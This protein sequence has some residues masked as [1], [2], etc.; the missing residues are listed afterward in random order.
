MKIFIET[1]RLLLRELTETDYPGIFEL[2]SDPEVHQYLGK[3]PISNIEDA[4][5][6]IEMIRAQYIQ[7]GIGRWAVIRKDTQE[8]IGWG[9]LKLI[10]DRVNDHQNYY[11][12]GYRLI[13][14]HWGKGYASEIASATAKYAF[15][16]L[17]LPEIYAI[18]DHQNLASQ[19]ILGKTGFSPIETFNYEGVPH[20]WYE[21]NFPD[22]KPPVL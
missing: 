15:N 19:H 4:K 21:K 17:N 6:S 10:T 13:K 12:L 16:E 8:F 5:K 9:G 18:A 20:I 1:S 22:I 14:S 3:K 7:N 11:D 2:D